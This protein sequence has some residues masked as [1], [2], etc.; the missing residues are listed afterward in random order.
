MEKTTY[1]E[2]RKTQPNKDFI[3]SLQTSLQDW[4]ISQEEAQELTE[5]YKNIQWNILAISKEELN[6]LAQALEINNPSL[7]KVL[8]KLIEKSKET[9]Y[10]IQESS[11]IDEEVTSQI[12][13]ESNNWQTSFQITPTEVEQVSILEKIPNI[14]EQKDL[15]RYRRVLLW[16]RESISDLQ[17]SMVENTDFIWRVWDNLIG[18]LKFVWL[19]N[20]ETWEDIYKRAFENI[21]QNAKNTWE[22]IVIEWEWKVI[23]EDQKGKIN[24]LQK[25][26]EAL[27]WETFQ[28]PSTFQVL[29]NTDYTQYAKYWFYG[30][31]WVVQ[32]AWNWAKWAVEFL[33][34]GLWILAA[35]AIDDN[36]R[37]Q[38]K[39]D[40]AFIW[41]KL[42]P[43]NAKKAADMILQ[44]LEEV[45]ELPG[46]QQSEALWKITWEI[47]II[48]LWTSFIANAG[49]SVSQWG[50]QLVSSWVANISRWNIGTWTLQVAWWTTE[51]IW[52][53]GSVVAAELIWFTW[54][55]K[56]A[57]WV[58]KTMEEWTSLST[59]IVDNN[60]TTVEFTWWI[61]AEGVF[62]NG[63]L[64]EW[65][66]IYPNGNLEIIENGVRVRMEKVITLDDSSSWIQAIP[67]S[68]ISE[69]IVP[70]L[71][72]SQNDVLR[73]GG[74]PEWG[75]IW[76]I[77]DFNS[78]FLYENLEYRSIR[79]NNIKT[80]ANILKTKEIPWQKHLLGKE[81][82]VKTDNLVQVERV[83][84]D[85]NFYKWYI[86]KSWNPI[87]WLLLKGDDT[88]VQYLNWWEIWRWKVLIWET[89]GN[90]LLRSG[91]LQVRVHL[92][93]IKNSLYSEINWKIVSVPFSKEIKLVHDSWRIEIWFF[94]QDWYLVS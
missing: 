2:A 56:A 16:Y 31:S 75:N 3:T 23:S 71:W 59:Q 83:L 1:Q 30:T 45:L 28:S 41:S 26:F 52:W 47:A 67:Q 57:R 49:R 72:L 65:T 76:K 85:W 17:N 11:S 80:D 39:K 82:F 10:L 69:N 21:L 46:E 78:R 12:T 58:W 66:I 5:K 29:S 53:A 27:F 51:T 91:W 42:T 22:K 19:T 93:T 79:S 94:N 24:D 36:A 18:W 43:E 88:V 64:F 13:N 54:S 6:N 4:V 89:N 33:W 50:T 60:F 15:D 8:N 7:K 87:H 74:I 32:W 68:W 84:W 70:H 9:S 63:E 61:K 37:E 34:K 81:K 35:A 55:S 25:D 44:K 86:D 40:V 48:F 20:R 38:F 73:L 14:L 77:P 62:K 90:V 92:N